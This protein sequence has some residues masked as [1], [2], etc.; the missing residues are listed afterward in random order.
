MRN[1]TIW[2]ASAALLVA[3]N[4]PASAGKTYVASATEALPK[5]AGLVVKGFRT[6]PVS[7]AV[8]ATWR[9]QSK[10]IMI[11][12]DVES[13]GDEQTFSYVCVVTR[14]SAFVQRTMN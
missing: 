5:I 3:A 6:R 12:L 7:P 10:S 13:Q 1:V 8:L 14:G 4:S 11:D 9:G 2:A